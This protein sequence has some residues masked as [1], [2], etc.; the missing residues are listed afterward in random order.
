[1]VHF[2]SF[3]RDIIEKKNKKIST[4]SRTKKAGPMWTRNRIWLFQSLRMQN[5]SELNFFQKVDQ[6]GPGPLNVDQNRYLLRISYDP[7]GAGLSVLGSQKQGENIPV[8]LR[9]LLLEVIRMNGRSAFPGGL[10]RPCLGPRTAG[11]EM[12]WFIL[13]FILGLYLVSVIYNLF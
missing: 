7:E 13:P 11:S 6:C 10:S 4:E 1:M 8:L 3:Y 12:R 2:F 9:L 5:S